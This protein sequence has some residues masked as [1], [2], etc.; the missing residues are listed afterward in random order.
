MIDN[1]KKRKPRE[2]GGYSIQVSFNKYEAYIVHWVD[3]KY[4][5]ISF[6]SYVKDLIKKEMNGDSSTTIPNQTPLTEDEIKQF[7]EMLKNLESM[8]SNEVTNTSV[9][10]KNFIQQQ[11]T[12]TQ[13]FQ[14][15]QQPIVEQSHEPMV[16]HTQ[17]QTVTQPVKETVEKKQDI[18]TTMPPIHPP[19]NKSKGNKL[20]NKSVLDLL[21]G[22]P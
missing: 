15:P 13:Q 19:N 2:D 3:E 22:L 21:N 17:G 12:Q 5:Y 18:K 7:R 8:K 4:P 14:Q 6:S 1:S 16:G 20:D 10:D 11:V 9:A